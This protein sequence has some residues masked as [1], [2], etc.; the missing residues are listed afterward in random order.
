MAS[1]VTYGNKL[2]R[3]EFTLTPGGTR[4][5]IRLGRMTSKRAKAAHERIEQLITD[6]LLN[7]PH[8]AELSRWM[9]ELDETILGRLRAAG[10]ASGVGL[11]R[12]SLGGF[13]ERFQKNH[14]VKPSTATFY[15]HTRRNLTDYF[16]AARLICDITEADADGWRSWLSDHEKLAPA[17]VGRRVIAARTIWKKAVRWKLTPTNP[18]SEVRGG[19]QQ[20]DENKHF[21]SQEEIARVLDACPDAQ[22]RSLVALARYGGLRNPSET[23]ALRW[24]DINWDDETGSM[25]VNSKKTAHHEGKGTRLVPLFPQLRDELLTAFE[26]AEEGAVHVIERYRESTQN[27]G[28]QFARIVKAAGL[29]P[30]PRLWQN[31]RA[32]RETELIREHGI[33]QACRWIGNSPAVAAKHYDMIMEQH[34]AKAKTDEKEAQQKAQQIAQQTP[35]DTAGQD[36]TLEAP[37]DQ[38]PLKN[39]ASDTS[40][41][42]MAESV[43]GVEWAIQDLN[44]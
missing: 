26:E 42:E 22:W 4:R 11:T 30:W 24:Q 23:L 29:K 14:K 39:N 10:L 3:I 17:T 38:N 5:V 35:P 7:R 36:E 1:L 12:T 21:V 6:K 16:G 13:L 18:F 33:A 37:I 9:S 25:L 2:R 27:L 43:G 41:R 20:N 15:G 32:S 28:T 31:L 8:D 40:C 34:P 19:S 44:L